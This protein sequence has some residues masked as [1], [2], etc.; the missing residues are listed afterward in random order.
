[1]DTSMRVVA[2]VVGLV[3]LIGM[4]LAAGIWLG[5]LQNRVQTLEKKQIYEHGDFALP[6]SA[7]E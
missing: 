4:L 6:S 1:M 7:Q 2:A 3:T 5:T